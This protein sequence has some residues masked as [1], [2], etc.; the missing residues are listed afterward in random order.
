MYGIMPTGARRRVTTMVGSGAPRVNRTRW[1]NLT[2]LLMLSV[3]ERGV[4]S[5]AVITL[6]G[7]PGKAGLHTFPACPQGQAPAAGGVP[8][9]GIETPC[10]QIMDSALGKD[11]S[12]VRTGHTKHTLLRPDWVP[13]TGIAH[14]RPAAWHKDCL[15]RLVGFNPKSNAIVQPPAKWAT[16]TAMPPSGC[17]QTIGRASGGENVTMQKWTKPVLVKLDIAETLRGSGPCPDGDGG[18]EAM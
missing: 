3:P 13:R 2:N 18:S 10:H 15:C 17:I 9:S 12:R 5:F 16:I 4:D 11:D 7:R 1:H 8:V 6:F 14:K